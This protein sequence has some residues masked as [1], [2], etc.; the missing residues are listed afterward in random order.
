MSQSRL[1][2]E[3]DSWRLIK[4]PRTASR[5]EEQSLV[6]AILDC[7]HEAV[8]L[9]D[10]VYGPAIHRIVSAALTFRWNED[11]ERELYWLAI[12]KL[13]CGLVYKKR[14][15][16]WV[17]VPER[18]PIQRW[19]THPEQP[20]AHFIGSVVANFVR[21]RWVYE[22][23]F[24]LVPSG[25]RDEL[26]PEHASF[27]TEPQQTTDIEEEELA[28]TVLA[29]VAQLTDGERVAFLQR[30]VEGKSVKL[31]AEAMGKSETAVSLHI[32][33]A[34]KKLRTNPRLKRA[35]GELRGEMG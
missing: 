10:R 2:D 22:Y 29:A 25:S 32:H 14:D 16:D 17:A 13:M 12:E 1:P 9:F 20:L 35:F 8:T 6:A 7:N 26:E 21:T 23:I 5:P 24:D 3:R 15:R 18:P 30:H 31:I 34:L 33:R 4:D 28:G 11:R 27:A 19:L